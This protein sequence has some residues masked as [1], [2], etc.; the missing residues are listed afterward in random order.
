MENQQ[1][2]CGQTVSNENIGGAGNH[3]CRFDFLLSSECLTKINS[4]L[5]LIYKNPQNNI[6]TMYVLRNIIIDRLFINIRISK[7]TVRVFH[8]A[9]MCPTD[10]CE[11]VDGLRM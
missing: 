8:N 10:Q 5:E 3:N 9:I 11:Y 6:K 2:N 7:S 1:Q 4:L